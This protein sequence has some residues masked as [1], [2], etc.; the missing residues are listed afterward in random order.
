MPV[1]RGERLV[2][3]SDPMHILLVRGQPA[4]GSRIR[5]A[6]EGARLCSDLHAVGGC[7]DARAYLKGEGEFAGLPR[8]DLILFDLDLP[9]QCGR[10]LITEIKKDTDLKGIPIVVMRSDEGTR[11]IP[12]YDLHRRL[13]AM[14]PADLKLFLGVQENGVSDLKGTKVKLARS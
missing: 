14:T 9:K 12:R 5:E 10:D 13:Y 2:I 6:V 7:G 8:P 11:E 1:R 3:S 4:N